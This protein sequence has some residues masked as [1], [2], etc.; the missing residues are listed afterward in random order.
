M[1]RAVE[2]ALAFALAP[3]AACLVDNPLWDGPSASDGAGSD[4]TVGDGGGG[5]PAHPGCQREPTA[6]S[7]PTIEVTPAEAAQLDEIA[8][9]AAPGTALVLADGVYPRAGEPAID[10]AAPGLQLRSASGDPASVVI[11]GGSSVPELVIV[12]SDDVLIAELT[13]Q[14][15]ENLVRVDPGVGAPVARPRLHR[16][17]MRDASGFGLAIEA[18]YESDAYA[19]DGTVSCSV[20]TLGDELRQTLPSCQSTAAIKAFGAAGWVVRDNVFADFWCPN[21]QTFAAVNFTAGSRDTLVERNEFRDDFRALVIGFEAV[22]G[23]GRRPSPA[24]DCPTT[25]MHFGGTIANNMLWVG[26][27]DL[28]ASSVGVDAMIS[29]WSACDVEVQHNTVVALLPVFSAIEYRFSDTTGTIANN[30][31]SGTVRERDPAA[32]VVAGN[33]EN[34]GLEAFVDPGAGDLHLVPAASA[35]IDVGV[36]VGAGPPAVDFDGDPRDAAPDVGA[37]ELVP[38]G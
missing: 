23:E 37:D 10:L 13:L 3:L 6:A 18:D 19:D 29:V 24:G 11:D 16:M 7:Q 12:R 26:G 8:A 5:S 32:I 22:P 34:V 14:G 30:L 15:A 35:A 36:A 2:I 21:S 31:L 38:S 9:A 27:A 20:F 33:V 17:H 4:T 1:G 28:A 25:A